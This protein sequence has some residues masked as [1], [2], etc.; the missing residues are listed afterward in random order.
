MKLKSKKK[1]IHVTER[2]SVDNSDLI[3]VKNYANGKLSS[4]NLQGKGPH[5]THPTLVKP[6]FKEFI[7]KSN[8]F[9]DYKG[10]AEHYYELGEPLNMQDVDFD[11]AVKDGLIYY[12]YGAGHVLFDTKGNPVP[13][14]HTYGYGMTDFH[15]RA[16]D[17]EKAKKVLEKH[18]WV[19]NRDDLQII[20][21]PYYN[22]QGYNHKYIAVTILPDAKAF[23]KMYDMAV[24]A[25]GG[26]KEFFSCR[27]HE[28]VAGKCYV[29]P[30]FDPLK[31][32]K[33]R[34]KEVEVEVDEDED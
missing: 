28:L 25:G 29:Y 30:D 20:D 24:K 21:V 33:L 7:K 18:P 16:V 27:L 23:K 26:G 31:L 22:A 19:L 15:N 14:P 1:T 3:V 13:L 11:Q 8:P 17:I 34:K 12:F 5:G 2:Y 32:H 9:H 10:A 4:I 6:S